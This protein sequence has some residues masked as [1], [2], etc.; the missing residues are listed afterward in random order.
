VGQ[1]AVPCWSPGK[2]GKGGRRQRGDVFW[3]RSVTALLAINRQAGI[4]AHRCKGDLVQGSP[5]HLLAWGGSTSDPQ[6]AGEEGGTRV[7]SGLRAVFPLPSRPTPA[8]R[9]LWT[10]PRTLLDPGASLSH[11]TGLGTRESELGGLPHPVPVPTR[12]GVLGRKRAFPA[13]LARGY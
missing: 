12:V 3:P 11:P 2:W 4:P 13:P 8:G 6:R 1:H 10:T 5:P 7:S 9:G